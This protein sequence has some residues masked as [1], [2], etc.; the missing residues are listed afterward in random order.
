MAL[1]Y[2]KSTG[3]QGPPILTRV[4]H[5][6]GPHHLSQPVLPSLTLHPSPWVGSFHRAQRAP[7]PPRSHLRLPDPPFEPQCGQPFQ[8]ASCAPQPDM[9]LPLELPRRPP[10][11][12][13]PTP[14]GQGLVCLVPHVVP[15]RRHAL[16]EWQIA[17]SLVWTQLR[18]CVTFS[19]WFKRLGGP[20]ACSSCLP[21]PTSAY[22]SRPSVVLHPLRGT[23]IVTL[24]PTTE[25]VG[26]F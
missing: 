8:E 12:L 26:C 1:P 4:P 21:G 22:S 23:P 18:R 20:G 17:G 3:A 15:R 7:P 2:L 14:L 9:G 5:D 19:G 24:A 11:T 16:S 10:C 13:P 6:L 25:P